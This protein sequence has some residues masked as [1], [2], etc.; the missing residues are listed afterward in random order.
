MQNQQDNLA[1]RLLSMLPLATSAPPVQEQCGI[2]PEP[3]EKTPRGQILID[4][5]ALSVRRVFPAPILEVLEFIFIEQVIFPY[6]PIAHQGKANAPLFLLCMHA[7]SVAK[8]LTYSLLQDLV[9]PTCLP[10]SA[11]ALPLARSMLT[12]LLSLTRA[13]SATTQGLCAFCSLS[14]NVS[15]QCAHG[16]PFQVFTRMLHNFSVCSSLTSLLK[17]HYSLYLHSYPFSVF[18]QSTYHALLYLLC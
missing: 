12:P 7:C 16:S 14:W 5:P 4:Q 8:V 13:R 3:G 11:S 2:A 17:F 6:C 9:A 1:L 15:S 10:S 18:L